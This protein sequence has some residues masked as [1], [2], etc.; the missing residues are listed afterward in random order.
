L[1]KNGDRL[2]TYRE[3]R[4][5]SRTPEPA[6]SRTRKSKGRLGYLI[7]KHD[8]TRLHYDFRLEHDG[9]LLSWAIPKGPDY[10]TT[11]K[12]LAVRTED[13]PIEYGKFEGTI[14]EDEYGGGTVMLWDRGHWEPE[15]DVDEGL[16]KGKL[17]F[18]VF[19]ERIKG[20]WAFVRLRGRKGDRGKENW[21]LIK[22]RDDLAG[23]EKHPVVERELKSIKTGR[24]MEEI[25]RG[26][27]VWHSNKAKAAAKEKIVRRERRAAKSKRKA[28]ST[29]KKRRKSRS[30][31][32]PLP[33]F[34][35]PQL[36]SLVESPPPGKD[37]LHEIKYDGYRAIAAVG[38]GGVKIYTRKGLD[39]TDK[40]QPLLTP[41]ADLPCENALLDGEIAIAD[42]RGHTNFSALQEALSERTGGFGYYLFD[43]LHLNGKDLRQRPLIE[44]K[45][46][47]RALLGNRQRAPLFYSDHIE[48]AGDAAY[49]H[50]CDLKLEGIISK[51][52]KAAYRSGRAKSWLKS[53]CGMEQ[54]FVIIGWTP[55]DKTGREFRS[56][57]VAVNEEGA[58]RYA[59]RVGSGFD[60]DTLGKLATLFKRY[61]RRT[62]PA[63]GVPAAIA[64]KSKFVEPKLVGEFAFRGWTGDDL[65][66]QGS[67][68]GLRED[69]PAREIVRERPMARSGKTAKARGGS[70]KKAKAAKAKATTFSDDG[71]PEIAGVR[72]T[73]P[74]RVLYPGTKITK[75]EL[76]A[77]YLKVAD[78]MLPHIA[79]RPIS[80]VRCPRG[81]GQKCF[82][83]K[84]ANEGWPD[85]FKTVRI[86]E[87]S[88]TDDYLYIEDEAGLVASVQMGVLELHLWGSMADDVEKPNRMIFDLDPD[89][90]L[91]FAEVKDA[92]KDL[93]KR[94]EGLD[95]ES[96]PMATGGKGLHLIV[97]LT[98]GHSWDDHRNFAEAVA[99]V[100]AEEEP[101]R[102]VATMSK[103]KRRGKIF[104]DY[105]RNQRGATAI[106]PFSSRARKGAPVAWP[107][108]W[109]QLARLKNAQPAHVDEF[110]LG[111]DPWKGYFRTRQKLPRL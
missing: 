55:S 82:F 1:L 105:L 36:A 44:R 62:S 27:K 102:F 87:K 96:F 35:S 95:L 72:V 79:D 17:A 48:G 91:G 46:K 104:V 57:L 30:G 111:A 71:N 20:K 14:P 90:G 85:D 42:A 109:S 78:R 19:G 93:K 88:G 54:E 58:L 80:L 4:D 89:E 53:K 69:K 56:L 98:P 32:L 3:K 74:D 110:K 103:A 64:R 24:T 7:Q 41:L 18:K 37:W 59:G 49:S 10:D 45:G 101:E 5:F 8:A 65:V 73:H 16:A 81:A 67:F 31:D 51:A 6:P 60:G 47:L 106:A 21:L 40:F 76:I 39:W 68:K 26:R 83:Q 63:E 11:V 108:S 29:A 61:A 33:R 100:M 9:A 97:P 84:H 43:L 66:R 13:H 22:E 15:G 12:R 86:K 52:A 77:Y 23:P 50:A 92:A 25:A 34:V 38:A 70:A 2:R 94:L 28:E 75:Q 107:V 99:R